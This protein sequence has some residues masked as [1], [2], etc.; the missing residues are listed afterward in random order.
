MHFCDRC[1]NVCKIYDDIAAKKVY[2]VCNPCNYTIELTNNCVYS[3][4]FN[5]NAMGGNGSDTSGIIRFDP[6]LPKNNARKC[7][8]CHGNDTVFIRN[9]DLTLNYICKSCG[10]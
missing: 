7:T 6:T 9:S 10:V 8:E 2:N 4:I 1:N 5:K 3:K